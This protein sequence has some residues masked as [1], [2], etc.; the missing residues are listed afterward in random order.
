MS[1]MMTCYVRNLPHWQPSG[2]D[3]FITWRLHGSLP[4]Q[5]R[6]K[7][8]PLDSR[9]KIF[10]RYDRVL[11]QARTGPLW[12]KDPRVAETVLTM[13]RTG[14]MRKMLTLRAYSI[15][16]NHVHVLLTPR[17]PI[18][19]ITRQMKGATAREA[20]VILRRTGAAFWQDES[21]DHWIRTPGEWQKV[22]HYIEH[23]PVA[24][25]LVEKAEDWP[26]SSAAR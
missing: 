19:E 8:I 2:V 23:N 14:E 26:W 5:L 18:S 9:G 3:I 7:S 10:V 12:L 20:N 6:P 1:S 25:G 24:A 13:L 4:A 16:S 11:D 22:R 15:M 17:L 21:F